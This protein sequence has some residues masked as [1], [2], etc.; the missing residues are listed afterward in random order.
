MAARRKRASEMCGAYRL[1]TMFHTVIG[2]SI[3]LQIRR[4]FPDQ[5][6]AAGP[7]SL[8]LFSDA[9]TGLICKT[10]PTVK[11]YLH[12]GTLAMIRFSKNNA[13]TKVTNLITRTCKDLGPGQQPW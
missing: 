5:L 9:R 6:R 2:A 11:H 3:K 4:G 10:E 13:R 7:S 8:P 1:P 12:P